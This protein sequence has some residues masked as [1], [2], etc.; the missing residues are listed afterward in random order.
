MYCIYTDRNVA[1]AD[2]NL[3]H[4]IPLSL[5]GADDFTVWSEEKFNS[6]MGGTVD[7][8]IHKDFFLGPALRDSGVKGHNRKPAI[9]RVRGATIDG[10]PAQVSLTAEG[11]KV[12]DARARRDLADEE[13]VG[14]EIGLKFTVDAFSAL[15]FVA[16][17]ALGG[18]YA[19]YG[20]P[21][22]R[23]VTCGLL[24]RVIELDV[25]KARLAPVLRKG[26]LV[27]CDRWHK[28]SQP[29]GPAY[30]YRVLCEQIPRSLLVCQLFANGMAF[31]VGVVG[32]YL[33]T[34]FCP[35][36]TSEL[37]QDGD[38]EGGHV[39]VLAP[40]K[41]ERLSFDALVRDLLAFIAKMKSGAPDADGGV[42][43]GDG[44]E[45]A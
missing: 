31:H 15:R 18:G 44:D 9:P 42:E 19:I 6:R 20:D 32:E 21:F 40:G 28:D 27:A 22:R 26:G 38:Y 17:V 11:F 35:G 10:R 13:I 5:G 45:P 30:Q 14:S 8:A 34:L 12:W 25:A 33:G 7:G 4:V 37:P 41:T 16:K 39:V 1:E 3:D 36:D 43:K 2:G 24:R 29:G 23:A